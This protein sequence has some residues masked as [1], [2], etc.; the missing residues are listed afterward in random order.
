MLIALHELLGASQDFRDEMVLRRELPSELGGRVVGDVDLPPESR[1]ER[2][3]N[4]CKVGDT[5]IAD[6]HQVD[7]TERVLSAAGDRSVDERTSDAF[8][9]RHEE[10]TKHWEDAGGFVDQPSQIEKQRRS[11]VGLEVDPRALSTLLEN[12]S[13]NER[14]QLALQA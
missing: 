13:L 10:T 11:T 5:D 9:K 2:F 12:A 8:L 4:R 1:L 7:V 3:E 14:L 6:Y